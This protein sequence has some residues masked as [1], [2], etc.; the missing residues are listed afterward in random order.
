MQVSNRILALAFA[1]LALVAGCGQDRQTQQ[2]STETP[3]PVTDV[4]APEST[5][6]TGPAWVADLLRSEAALGETVDQGRLA[7][8]HDKAMGL[9][10]LLKQ[11]AE[12]VTTLAPEQ[13]QM[14]KEHLDGSSRL[15]D[16]LHDAGDA[17]DLTKAK[18][19]FLEF[20]THM[21]A[22]EGAFGAARP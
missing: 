22:I 8:V 18:A 19:K 21:R 6:T 17:G 4:S 16:E 7:E 10:S 5:T 9:Q 11:V 14:L 2:T 13:Q 3:A 20:Q 1:S 12:Q 15:M